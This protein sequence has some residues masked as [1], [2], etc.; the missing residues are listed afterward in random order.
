MAL[1]LNIGKCTLLGNY[2]E[3]N[4]DAIDVRQ[5]SEMTICV[6]A[7]GMGGQ[8]A[9]EIA[10]KQ[11]IEILPREIKNNLAGVTSED[12]TRQVIRSAIVHANAVI[13]DMASMDRDL[14]NMGTT[15]VLALWPKGSNRLY[16]ANIGDSRAYHITTG[17]IEQ[18]TVDH[19]IAQALVET[20]TISAAEARVHKYRNVL[21]KYLGCKEV[22]DGP[23]VKVLT[24]H[25]G[26]RYLLCTDGLTGVVPDETLQR[27][28][29]ENGNVQHCADE[30]GQ[31]ALDSGSKDNV[32][33][34]VMEFT[35]S[36]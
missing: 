4:E 26:D 12:E 13:M 23:E 24:L 10:S 3:N 5:F 32:S 6:V 25:K 20:R 8:Q 33:C 7:D 11:A 17:K 15:V 35:E 30:L 34:I 31:L 18:L 14:N 28:V 29:L 36:R 16:V 21:W 2:R 1:G 19:S 9:G 27:V 22:G